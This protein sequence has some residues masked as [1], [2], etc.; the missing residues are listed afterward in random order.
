MRGDG[1]LR[2]AINSLL[3]PNNSDYTDEQFSIRKIISEIDGGIIVRSADVNIVS[4]LL[5][6]ANRLSE[7]PLIHHNKLKIKF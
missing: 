1:G 6:S 2:G 5:I 3:I 4:F 7:V